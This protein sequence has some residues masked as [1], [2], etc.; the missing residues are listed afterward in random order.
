M[1]HRRQTALELGWHATATGHPVMPGARRVACVCVGVLLV[2]VMVLPY[3]DHRRPHHYRSSFRRR[4]AEPL[5]V[6]FRTANVGM[7]SQSTHGLC[8]MPD[9]VLTLV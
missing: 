2:V 9:T 6:P 1:D 3:D 4:R 8:G 5:A 7:R